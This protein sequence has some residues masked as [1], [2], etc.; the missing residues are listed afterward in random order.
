MIISLV[1]MELSI[2]TQQTLCNE[3]FLTLIPSGLFLLSENLLLF[4]WRI[5]FI[6]T[7]LTFL[8]LK[9]FTLYIYIC[10]ENLHLLPANYDISC[11]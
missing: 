6:L 11:N 9:E 3:S 2:L 4:L 10:V 7:R 1:S 5:F 8:K